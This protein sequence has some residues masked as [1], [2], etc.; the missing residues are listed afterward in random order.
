MTV[1]HKRTT[2]ISTTVP[3]PIHPPTPNGPPA[4]G[5]TI[6]QNDAASTG[7][8]LLGDAA[9]LS[10]SSYGVALAAGASLVL[11]DTGGGSALYALAS[12][13]TVNANVLHLPS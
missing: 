10:S 3:T 13:G 5:V 8:L 6:V 1:Q 2:A 4:P 7:S 9:T 11:P 12:T